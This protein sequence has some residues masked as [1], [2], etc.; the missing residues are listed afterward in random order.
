[1]EAQQCVELTSTNRPFG[2]II[3]LTQTVNRFAIGHEKSVSLKLATGWVRKND[4]DKGSLVNIAV[5]SARVSGFVL[6]NSE[7]KKA[8]LV[9]PANLLRLHRAVAGVCGPRCGHTFSVVGARA[10]IYARYQFPVVI[11]RGSHP[12]PSRTR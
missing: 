3:K 10:M 12:F 5:R 9:M 1:M 8:E 2:L 4:P 6:T 7:Q 11:S